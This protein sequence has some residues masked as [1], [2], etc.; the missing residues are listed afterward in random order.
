MQVKHGSL[1]PDLPQ[2]RH[3]CKLPCD[4]C[5]SWR[6]VKKSSPKQRRSLRPEIRSAGVAGAGD[7]MLV[8]LVVVAGG[9]VVMEEGVVAWRS[10]SSSSRPGLLWL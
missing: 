5:F 8:L 10:R 9:V 6:V 4:R 1:I 3:L 2:T 7:L